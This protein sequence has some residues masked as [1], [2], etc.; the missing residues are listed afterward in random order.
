MGC[1]TTTLIR[2]VPAVVDLRLY[3]G[4]DV[5]LRVVVTDPDTNGPA[6]LTG[7]TAQSQIRSTATATD[8]MCE[9]DVE[10]VDNIVYLTLDS[11]ATT[12]QT[13]RGVWD[14]QLTDPDGVVETVAGGRVTWVAEVTR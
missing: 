8:I 10:I 13:G 5:F 2:I 11:A 4:D 14:V 3:E 6:D 9:F 1:T 12:G 7:Y